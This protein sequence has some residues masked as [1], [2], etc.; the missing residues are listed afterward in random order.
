MNAEDIA[1]RFDGRKGW[2]LIDC[3]EVAL[4]LYR[5]TVDAVTM[6]HRGLPP[7]KEFVM[8]AAAAGLAT[9]PEISGFLGLEELPV[10]A[11]LGQLRDEGLAS[12]DDAGQSVV[13]L[14]KGK[15]V[16]EK[17]RESAPQDEMLV[18]LFDGLLRK[19]VWLGSEALFTPADIDPSVAIEVRPYPAAPPELTDLALPDVVQVIEKQNGGKASFGKDILRLKRVVRRVRLF[20]MGVALVFRKPKTSDI[21]ISFVVD[22]TR[23]EALEHAFAEKGGPK[24]MGFIKDLNESNAVGAIRRHLGQE[25]IRRLPDP[26]DHD[27]KRIRVSLARLRRDI[28]A[29]QLE[30][31]PEG[32]ENVDARRALTLAEQ[33]LAAADE[34]LRS[35]DARPIAVYEVPELIERAIVRSQ[36]FLAIS[37]RGIRRPILTRPRLKQLE[38]ALARGVKVVLAIGETRAEAKPSKHYDPLAELAKLGRLYPNLDVRPGH[39]SELF[40]AISDDSFALICNRPLLGDSRKTKAFS[41]FSGFVLQSAELVRPYATR[42]YDIDHGLVDKGAK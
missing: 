22:E 1:R 19:P 15:A 12:V 38:A 8:K 10:R 26:A 32:S 42:F 9:L 34:S 7:I 24:K 25:T 4:P 17:Q 2:D 36:E 3:S 5:L 30:N 6:A 39:K 18:F 28:A 40:H 14:D 11:V 13:L 37:S 27:A 31:S 29:V 35:S 21:Q 41:H 20:R 23:L 33:E 16:L